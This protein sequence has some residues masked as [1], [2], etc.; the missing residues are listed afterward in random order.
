MVSKGEFKNSLI[1][2]PV[3]L[4]NYLKEDITQQDLILT[5]ITHGG[6]SLDITCIRSMVV[7]RFNITWIH[8][9]SFKLMDVKEKKLNTTIMQ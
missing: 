1:L 6:T 8:L 4:D 5:F 3:V 2:N 9:R 7:Y